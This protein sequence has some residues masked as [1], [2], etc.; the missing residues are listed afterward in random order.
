M[1]K[2][3]GN[4]AF[5][6]ISLDQS[7]VNSSISQT[8]I[9]SLNLVNIQ[10]KSVNLNDKNIRNEI[11]LSRVPPWLCTVIWISLG[12]AMI[13]F[14]K[15]ILA[16][17]SQGGYNF[18][19]PFFLTMCHQLFA[20]FATQILNKYTPLLASVKEGKLSKESYW[21]KVVPLALFFALGLV[22]GNSAYKYL[23][24]SYIQMIKST[25]PIPTLLVS[26]ALGRERPTCT[27]VLLVFV[28]CI[29]AIIASLGELQFSWWGL[30][31]Q[32]SA[33]C[34][35]TYHSNR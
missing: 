28:I 5:D 15:A 19:Y 6:S 24:V 16:P 32:G 17:A 11:D 33:L 13:M 2:N 23:S 14:N 20:I 4:V 27:Q 21:K 29:G 10:D 34:S 22:L 1:G 26:Y 3:D 18:S 30:L 25:L 35:G 7:S 31:L 12:I 9:T 8:K